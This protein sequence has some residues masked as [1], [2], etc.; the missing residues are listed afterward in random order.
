[1]RVLALSAQSAAEALAGAALQPRLRCLLIPM[2]TI[3][4][5]LEAC[6]DTVQV[7][8]L[9]QSERDRRDCTITGNILTF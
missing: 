9:H 5:G 1:M 3:Q 8:Q 6:L 7:C 2:E 4:S